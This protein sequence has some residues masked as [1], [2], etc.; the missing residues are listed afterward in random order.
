MFNIHDD[1]W[2]ESIDNMNVLSGRWAY[3]AV[4][5]PGFGFHL[6]AVLRNDSCSVLRSMV[7]EC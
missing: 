7:V 1:T 3:E 6:Q 5:D 2:A 4:I